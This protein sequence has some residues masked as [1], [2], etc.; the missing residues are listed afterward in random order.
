M[1]YEIVTLH[2]W[3]TDVACISSGSDMVCFFKRA[4]SDAI[5]ATVNYWIAGPSYFPSFSMIAISRHKASVLLHVFGKV[6]RDGVFFSLG[7]IILQLSLVVLT[8]ILKYRCWRWVELEQSKA[9]LLFGTCT[10]EK[11]PHL[12]SRLGHNFYRQCNWC[13]TSENNQDRIQRLHCYH[14]K[15]FKV[16]L[17]FQINWCI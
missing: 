16:H 5:K 6:F 3:C 4:F 15:L 9:T 10:F 17:Q 14:F 11:I 13:Y 2:F 8:D 7:N 1:E 12:S